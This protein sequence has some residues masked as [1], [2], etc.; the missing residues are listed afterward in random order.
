MIRVL[1][2]RNYSIS[3]H[4]SVLF[5]SVSSFPVLSL[6][7]ASNVLELSFLG[8]PVRFFS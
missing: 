7:V 3:R 6:F 2:E 8:F 1:A 4:F 5:F